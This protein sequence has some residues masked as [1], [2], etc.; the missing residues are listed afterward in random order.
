MRLLH[1]VENLDVRTPHLERPNVIEVSFDGVD[2]GRRLLK[3]SELGGSLRVAGQGEYDVVRVL[4]L[5]AGYSY[6][7]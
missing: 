5:Q 6:S 3:V 7:C 1:C 4:A 2:V